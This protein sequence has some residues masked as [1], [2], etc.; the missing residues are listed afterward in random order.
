MTR[1]LLLLILITVLPF[2]SNAQS[3]AETEEWIKKKLLE[4]RHVGIIGK[5][6]SYSYVSKDDIIFY[7]DSIYISRNNYNKQSKKWDQNTFY[8]LAIRDIKKVT[9]L[10]DDSPNWFATL[11][12][13]GY[14]PWTYYKEG[15]RSFENPFN[16]TLS[17]SFEENSNPERIEKAFKHLT[18]L[19]GGKY[20]K[21]P[22]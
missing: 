13:E 10:P 22:F 12:I 19:Y 14:N 7:K 4:Y 1:Y 8:K 9:F 18:S 17:T 11:S 20:Y 5:P 21:E 3:K 16:F 6:L 2:L 15:I